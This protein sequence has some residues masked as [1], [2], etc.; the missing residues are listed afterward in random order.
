MDRLTSH[1]GEAVAKIEALSYEGAGQHVFL[2]GDLQ[3]VAPNPFFQDRRV[4]FIVCNY[5]AGDDGTFHWH[6]SVTEYQM[7]LYGRVGL[8]EAATGSVYWYGPGDFSCVPAGVC[9]QRLVPV[10]TR[11]V[12]LKVPSVPGD[13]FHCADCARACDYR[14]SAFEGRGASQLSSR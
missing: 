11:T 8:K 12:A 3:K 14:V 5:D 4:E 6:D 13:K 10:S 9:V 7:V 1:P 2:T